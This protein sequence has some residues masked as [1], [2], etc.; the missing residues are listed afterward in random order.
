ME[1]K[2]REGTTRISDLFEKYTKSLIAPDSAVVEAFREIAEDLF[3]I[4]ISK[5]QCSYKSS[6]RTLRVTLSGPLKSEILLRKK[7]VLTHLKGRVGEHNAPED[8]L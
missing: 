2:R 8:I 7:E 6:T 1:R 3:G 4:T 5:Q